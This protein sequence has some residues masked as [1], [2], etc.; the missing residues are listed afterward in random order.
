MSDFYVFA[1]LYL[2]VALVVAWRTPGRPVG[3][4]LRGQLAVTRA[5]LGAALLW[6]E[7]WRAGL[8]PFSG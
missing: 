4:G 7:R 8:D 3:A 1:A 2:A 5:V 6:P